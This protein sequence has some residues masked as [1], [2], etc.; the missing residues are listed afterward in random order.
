MDSITQT[1]NW[2]RLANALQQENGDKIQIRFKTYDT[3]SASTLPLAKDHEAER[4]G[5][6]NSFIAM[7]SWKD[8]TTVI[9]PLCNKISHKFIKSIETSDG[10]PLLYADPLEEETEL[11]DMGPS[12]PKKP[13]IRRGEVNGINLDYII[14]GSGPLI[15]LLHDLFDTYAG[16]DKL[17]QHLSENYTV[18]APN[19]PGFGFSGKMTSTHTLE[20]AAD[21]M[22]A[23]IEGLEESG[24]HPAIC[25]NEERGPDKGLQGVRCRQPLMG[26]PKQ[27]NEADQSPGKLST[28]AKAAIVGHGYGGTLAWVL[29]YRRPDLVKSIAIVNG[30]HPVDFAKKLVSSTQLFRSWNFFLF[31]IPYLPQS[32][33][34]ANDASLF[35]AMIRSW[36][37]KPHALNLNAMASEMQRQGALDA[38]LAYYKGALWGFHPCKTSPYAGK[39]TVPVKVIWGENNRRLG[40]NLAEGAGHYATERVVAR[41]IPQT[42]HWIN[43]EAPEDLAKEINDMME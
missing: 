34:K 31:Q 20:A 30:P 14:E 29:A 24:K 10:S 8:L 40:S 27:G 1:S 28:S 7:C 39:V 6:K 16:F 4:E 19:L 15:V 12:E 26:L 2:Q 22:A 3:Y 18:A 36:S 33:L 21:I 13:A 23:F 35:K 41:T 43:R 25:V 9:D 37:E 11:D 17:I 42:G 38:A 32:I 5:D